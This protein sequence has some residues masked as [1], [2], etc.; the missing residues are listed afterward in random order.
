MNDSVLVLN[1]NF[2]PIHICNTHRAISLVIND[3][4]SLVLNGRGY[5]HTVSAAFPIPSVIRLDRMVNRPR[6]RVKFSRHE[7]FRRDGYTCQY[8]GK[9]VGELTIDHVIPRIFGGQHKWNNVV[10]AC[11]HCN[12]HKGGR[13]PEQAGMRL[14][15]RP[16]KPPASAQYYF[17]KFIQEN[18]N[19]EQFIKGW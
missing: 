16:D 9:S 17:E 2:E 13:T 19:W 15:A 12:H 18:Q 11:I 1:A 4:A 7:I 5:I 8:C 3:K 14:R 10:T 6:P